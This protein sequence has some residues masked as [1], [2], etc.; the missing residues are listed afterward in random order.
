MD[1][2][3]RFSEVF[4]PQISSRIQRRETVITLWKCDGVVLQAH[5]SKEENQLLVVFNLVEVLSPSLDRTPSHLASYHST[6]QHLVW[7]IVSF[8]H[9]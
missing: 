2:H 5:I 3:R 1:P 8:F 9:I 4:D 7:Y 6:I